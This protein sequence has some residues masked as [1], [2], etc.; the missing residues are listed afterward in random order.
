MLFFSTES[1]RIESDDSNE[2]RRRL[3]QQGA[4]VG[5]IM[6]PLSKRELE[7]RELQ[8]E[9]EPDEPKQHRRPQGFFT[10][11][12]PQRAAQEGRAWKVFHV[13]CW[14]ESTLRTAPLPARTVL[15]AAR[16]EGFNEWA[17]R[18]AKRHH[19]ISSKKVG[20]R[21]QGWG[22]VWVWEFPKS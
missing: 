13:R 14:L 3:K 19:G 7:A 4:N 18:R 8:P 1:T 6:F 2:W 22:A 11:R 9:L 17:P 15:R 12:D 5:R 21:R 16:K 20:G 10:A